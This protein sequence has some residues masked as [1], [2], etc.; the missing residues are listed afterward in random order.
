MALNDIKEYYRSW[1]MLLNAGA[2]W[3]YPSHGQP[4]DANLLRRDMGKHGRIV[5]FKVK[6]GKVVR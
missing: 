2:R 1:T 6:D 3:I 5:P 4:F